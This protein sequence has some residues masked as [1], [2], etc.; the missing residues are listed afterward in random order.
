M[1]E[2]TIEQYKQRILGYVKPSEEPLE[3][4][5]TTVKRIE[6]ALNGI[7]S[8]RLQEKKDDKWS[9]A[10]ILA[11][12]AEGE[13]VFG[14]R[15]RMILSSSGSPIQAYDQ[16]IFM[17]NAKY[18]AARPDMALALLRSLRRTNIEFLKSLTP[19]QWDYYGMHSE[20]GKETIRDITRLY[21]G[22]DLNHLQ[23]LERLQQ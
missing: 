8:E 16:N 12:Y 13:I 19:E 23:Q 3:I 11:H 10:E 7:S 17:Q 14:Y 6:K 5:K 22:H 20:R 15:I 18:L 2:E 4:L 1:P 21:A 9:A